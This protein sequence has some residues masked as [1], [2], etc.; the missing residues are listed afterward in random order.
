[1]EARISKE[2]YYMGVAKAVSARST[3]L[4]RKY[5]AVIVNNDEIVSTGY[6]GSPRGEPNC[7]D[8]GYCK[9]IGHAHNDGNYSEC[10]AVHAEQ[11]AISSASRDK[12]IGATLY[13]YGYDC[14]LKKD[15]HAEPC[16]IC[17][18]MIKNSG[19]HNV[20]GWTDD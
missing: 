6:N 19:I 14:E 5:G 18:R 7:C 8:N 15:I 1:M 11:N 10:P 3:C 9:R 13:L 4:R 2:K 12:M 17:T 16:P 20:V